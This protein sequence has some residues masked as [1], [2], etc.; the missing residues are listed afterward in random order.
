[1]GIAETTPTDDAEGRLGQFALALRQ[2]GLR[3]TH[4]RL[5]V[6]REIACS[7]KHPD[8]EAVYLGVRERVPTISLDTVYRTLGALEKLG[9]IRR[10]EVLGGPVRYDPVL[11]PHHHFICTECGLIQ[12]VYG[13][14][15]DELRAPE[16]TAGLGRV[17]AITVQLR[18]VCKS[19]QEKEY[20]DE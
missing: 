19:C 8:V 7:N 17:E 16:S 4:Q 20:R 15:Y 10:V 2:S 9:L 13:G 6:A 3:L 5:E 11:E 12:D 18:G 14:A 1:M